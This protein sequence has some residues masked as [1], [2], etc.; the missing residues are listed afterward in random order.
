MSNIGLV[1]IWSLLVISRV[2]AADKK[3]KITEQPFNNQHG[4]MLGPIGLGN[5]TQFTYMHLDTTVPGFFLVDSQC[6]TSG[7]TTNRNGYNTKQ[8]LSLI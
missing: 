4:A 2:D 5:P 1:F 6:K 3:R 7:C 8:E